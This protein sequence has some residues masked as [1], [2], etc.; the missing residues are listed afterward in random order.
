[1]LGA[2]ALLTRGRQQGVHREGEGHTDPAGSKTP[3][4]QGNTLYGNREAQSLAW[5]IAAR[6]ARRTREGYGRDER[7]LRV[8]QPHST[9]EA[10]EQG[11][12]RSHAGQLW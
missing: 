11:G 3:R 6:S 4:M 7:W 8:G 9:E 12:G 2:D 5:P 1:M 10:T